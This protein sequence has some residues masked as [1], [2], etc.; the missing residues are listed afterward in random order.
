MRRRDRTRGE[1]Q[2]GPA[3][4]VSRTSRWT[5]GVVVPAHDEAADIATCI[6]ALRR[7]LAL[8]TDVEESWI[9]VVADHCGDDTARRARLALGAAGEVVE[10]GAGNVGHAR[11][12]GAE[13][14]LVRLRQSDPARTWLLTTDA[15][16]TAPTGWVETQLRLATAGA[17]AVAGIVRVDS[18]AD[19][20]THVANRHAGAYVLAADGSHDHVHGANLGVRADGYRAVGGWAALRTGEDHDLWN[21]LRAGG[22]PVVASA[23]S[24]VTTS[25]RAVGRAPW[26][27]AWRLGTYGAEVPV[28]APAES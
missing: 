18:F 11:R 3:L 23:R 9:V 22:W 13:R 14:A 25:G 16:T 12:I 15:D 2:L 8:A 1:Q 7:A 27:F 20:P 24:W 19:H 21:R 5:V 10:I 4:S 6:Q 26:G 28:P 17:A